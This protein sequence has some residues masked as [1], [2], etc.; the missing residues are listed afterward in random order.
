MNKNSNK[1]I[2]MYSVVMVVIVA[3]MLAVT[4]QLLQPIQYENVLNEKKDAILA[5]L[6]AQDQNY[7]DYI[8]AYAI[9]AQGNKI[10]SITA[11]Y[12]I[13]T[14][15][16]DLAAAVK[17]KTFPVFQAKDGRIVV[18]VIG[19]GLWA[20]I[21]GYVALDKDLNTVVGAI[22]DHKGETPGLGAEIANA[23]FQ[24]RFVGK[25]IFNN[26]KFEGITLVKGGAIATDPNFINQ[27]DGISGGTRTADGVSDMLI[28]G[29]RNYLPLLE[30]L[31][32][33]EDE[34]CESNVEKSECNE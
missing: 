16:S 34:C 7:N 10:E 28:V 19:A 1:Y 13:S 4:A 17:A 9:D 15:M 11:D 22:L 32:G 23:E 8:T 31:S 14:L 2:I 33:C 27:V 26:G 3:T 5:S 18:P 25:Q 6:N 30:K 29:L 20:P 24:T 12:V 21:W